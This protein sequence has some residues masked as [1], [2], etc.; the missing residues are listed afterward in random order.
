MYVQ[1]N[2][3]RGIEMATYV[4]IDKTGGKLKFHNGAF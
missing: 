1:F 3:K 4:G 2:L